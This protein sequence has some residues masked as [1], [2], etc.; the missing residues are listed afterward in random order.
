MTRCQSRW[1]NAVIIALVVILRAPTL[2][3]SMY[4]SDEGYYG[5][6]ADDILDG[7]AVYHT[8]VDTKPPGMYYIYAAVFRVAGRNNLF[9]VH[10]LAI[11]VVVA[12]ALVLRRIGA[13]V[14]DDWAGAWSGIGYAVFV[15]AFWPGDTLGANSEIFASLPLSLSVLA[16][17]QGQKKPA[18]ALMFLSG[19][20]VG[21]ATLIRQPSGVILGALLAC[22][23]YGWLILGAHSF[24][25]VL[26]AGSGVV[27]GFIAVIA[28]LAWYYA[29]Q[30][31]LHGFCTFSS[32]FP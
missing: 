25:R 22:L 18:L 27:I 21:V 28:A 7:G 14:A 1:I 9:A 30:G 31:N 12:T 29:V 19:A 13:R 17:L 26:A 3:P 2:L 4:T 16:F 5:T 32:P 6:I 23:A 10:L 15:H 20:L 11:F 8:A 24:V